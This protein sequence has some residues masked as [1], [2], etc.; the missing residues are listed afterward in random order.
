MAGAWSASQLAHGAQYSHTTVP[1]SP[2]AIPGP[3]RGRV[4]AMEHRGSYVTGQFQA[5]AI[6]Q[7]VQRGMMELTGAPDWQS[8]WRVFFQAGD[9]VGIKVNPVGAPNVVSSPEV[10]RE[11][12]AGLNAAGVTNQN[13]FIYDRYRSGIYDAGMDQWAPAGVRIAWAVDAFELVQQSIQGYDPDH[14]VDLAL[15]LPGQQMSN[16]TARRSFAAQFLT[17]Q[18]NKIINLAVLKDHGSA[19]VTLA[20]KNLSHGFFNNTNRTHPNR[21]LNAVGGYIPAAVSTP[22][23][24]NKA[25]LHVLDGIRALYQ[26]GPSAWGPAV[27]E[28]YTLYFASDPVALDSIGWK[29]IDQKRLSVGLRPVGQHLTASLKRQPEHILIAGARGL[30]ESDA[31]RIVLR[32][33]VLG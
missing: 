26:G 18:V 6:Q 3:Y 8:A 32:K 33:V 23:I 10:L 9:V 11:L 29:Q 17:Q 4:A 16:L 12:V 31:A 24:R 7:M 22:A 25:V 5:G 15:T 14:Y 1:D 2:L 19:G 28:H 30:G 13:I 21:L 20:L 27:W